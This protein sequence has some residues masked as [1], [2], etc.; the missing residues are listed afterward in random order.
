VNLQS[1]LF[2][3]NNII[4]PTKN[5]IV[6]NHIIHKEPPNI[7]KSNYVIVEQKSFESIDIIS[8]D[9]KK[10]DAIN[11]KKH[12]EELKKF[13]KNERN[14][15]Y[16]NGETYKNTQ[17]L[18]WHTYLFGRMKASIRTRNTTAKRVYN[19]K[20]IKYN[21]GIAN[22]LPMIIPIMKKIYDYPN[23]TK[24]FLLKL[25]D[26]QN[27]LDAYTNQPM[28]VSSGL[29]SFKV[30]CDRIDSNVNYIKGNV[31]LC[32]YT[33]NLGKHEFNVFFDEPNSWMD[34]IT[35]YDPLKKQQ[36]RERIRT[37]QKLSME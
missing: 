19:K 2:S 22:G 13:Q 30:S 11:E 20:L 3:I 8:L 32:C 24:D 28:I 5:K 17:K 36:I 10:I 18:K 7:I 1:D 33:T 26:I 12:K 16:K 29:N 9:P 34:Y 15:N 6:G 4:V 21:N 25:W 35:N 27:G 37:I 31:V 14:K 23:F